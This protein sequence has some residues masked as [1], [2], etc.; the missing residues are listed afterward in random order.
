MKWF[1][2]MVKDIVWYFGW[3]RDRSHD[4]QAAEVENVVYVKSQASK[5]KGKHWRDKWLKKKT[6]IKAA[7]KKILTI[8]IPHQ[9]GKSNETLPSVRP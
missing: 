8:S 3:R 6:A 1:L 9:R 7:I 5:R 4:V 2:D